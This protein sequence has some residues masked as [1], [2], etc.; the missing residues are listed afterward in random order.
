MKIDSLVR[1]VEAADFSAFR[2]IALLCLE[3]RGFEPALVDGPHD[4]GADFRVYVMRGAAARFAVQISVEKDWKKKLRADAEKAKKRLGIDHLLFVSSRRIPE[5]EFQQVADELLSSKEVQVQKMDS[6]HIASLAEGRGFTSEILRALGISVAAPAP[7]PFQRPDLRQDVAYACAFFGTDAQAFRKTVI[8]NA[9]LAAIAQA[10]GS[11]EREAVMDR[12]AL[13]LGLTS[14][15]RAQVTSALDRMLQDGRLTGKN[16]AVTLDAKTSDNWL[17]VRALQDRERDDLRARIGELVAPF[18]KTKVARR[19][20]VESILED[21]GALW[22]DMGRA[23]SGALDTAEP[24]VLAQ[25]PL[26]QRLRHL[27]ATLDS[28]GV[29]DESRR[30]KL[31]RDLSK[32][33]AGS[34]FGRALAAGEVFINL[35]NLK[36]P[37][38]FRAFGAGKVL[39]AILDT[40]VA[41]PLLC[42]LLYDAAEQDFFVAAKHVYDQLE[43]HSVE[44]VLPRDY[45]EEVAS[46]LL[47]ALLLYGDIILLDPDLRGSKNAFVAHYTALAAIDDSKV[48]SYSSYLAAFGVTSAMAQGDR[49]VARDTLMNKLEGMF[50]RYGIRTEPLSGTA[51]STKK[52][53][54]ALLFAMRAR[55][56]LERPSILVNHD[57]NTL[58]WLLDHASD[59]DVVYV[60]CTWDKLHPYVR[61]REA[62]DWDVLDP[63]ALG[64]VLSLAAP[65]SEDMAII[66]PIVVALAL[67]SEAEKKG[68]AIWDRLVEIEREKLHDARL[69]AAAYDF[70]QAWVEGAVKDKRS[71]DL[72]EA[73]EKWKAAHLP[74]AVGQGS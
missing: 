74:E 68:A 72:Q 67:S 73:W 33:A 30:Q 10:G 69:R 28:L 6:Q 1:L 36:T 65:Q 52:A 35:M 24:V 49:R 34:S 38:I 23:A 54:E 13:S 2:E 11:A 62:A 9:A 42:S 7:K 32:L 46:H 48:G 41:M 19:D 21:L 59:P 22:L 64:D 71:R 3:R 31:L 15:Q 8:E 70:K 58:G 25:D 20:A 45:L 43:A 51:S 57:A 27:D 44:T 5:A 26:R 16:G 14:N 37:H 47:D 29:V 18:V 56:D 17:T 39:W 40:S 60:I 53:Q 12:A 66:S 55:N 61:S 50:K 4:G 63:V